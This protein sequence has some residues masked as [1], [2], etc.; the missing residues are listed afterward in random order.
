MDKIIA[1][2]TFLT[3]LA[4]MLLAFP[5]GIVAVLVTAIVSVPVII[6]IRQ[7]TDES[8]FLIQLF[9]VALILRMAFGVFIH[10]YDLRLF[11]G[12]DANTYDS[13]GKTILDIWFGVIPG[14]DPWSLRAMSTGTPG[15]G[16]N[17]LTAIIYL[18]TGR[19]IL[20][21]QSFCAVIGAATA[22]M[23]YICAHKIF[24]NRQVGKIAA[25]MV[26]LFPAFIIWSGQLLK[27]GLIIF[28]LVLA[29]TMVLQL[30]ERFNYFAVI[31]LVFALFGILSLRFY[32]F[33]MVAISV[34]GSFIVGQSGSATSIA[35]NFV[36]LI[37]VGIALTYLGVLRTASENF[38][39]WGNL[40]AVQRSRA[41]L[42]RSG[43]SGF[44]GDVDVSTTEGAIAAIPIGFTYLMLAP[45]PWQLTN[46]RQAITIPE[47]IVWWSS[48]PLLL[49]GLAYTIKNRLRNAIAI[50]IFTLML[51]IAYS[52]FQGNVG[53]AYR[54]RT[55][56][57]VFLFIFIAVGWTLRKEKRENQKLVN[58]AQRERLEGFLR[59]QRKI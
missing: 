38:D 4:V 29:M 54:Q 8:H 42:A 48:V 16:M 2:F 49:M 26:A 57:Q 58:A 41:D 43:A 45:F 3:A 25:L 59:E 31:F 37:V 5:D 21:A 23:V 47:M 32:I 18:F 6:L 44:G 52:I 9:L 12:G 17:Y 28:L 30:Q 13:L 27:D 35:R 10:L 19:N 40:D 53:T 1:I 15:W 56:I 33:Y 39:K 51:T 22:P 55:Q 20:A 7:N 24:H 14:N 34:A 46:L 36:L 11:F 50:L